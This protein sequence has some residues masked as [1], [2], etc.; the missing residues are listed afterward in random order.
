[1]TNIYKKIGWVVPAVTLSLVAGVMVGRYY[2]GDSAPRAETFAATPAAQSQNEQVLATLEALPTPQA[3]TEVTRTTSVDL[4]ETAIA[5][6]PVPQPA[7]KPVE[8]RIPTTADTAESAAF[9]AAAQANLQAENSCGDDLRALAGDA[10]VYFPTGGLSAGDAGLATA[11]LIGQVLRDCPGFT[12]QIEG[13]SDASG[14]PEFNRI[15][16]ERRANTVLSR[17]ASAGIDTSNFVALGLGDTQPS[18]VTG[19]EDDA[20]YDRRVE[21]TI[22]EDT[23]TASL[24][25]APQPWQ[26]TATPSSCIAVLQ[27]KAAQTRIFYTARAITVSPSEMETVKGLAAQTAACDGARLR[28]VGHH[29][30]TPAAREDASTG[31]LRVLAMM[32]S[33]VASGFESEKILIG[34]PSR[35]VDLAGQPGLPNS[36]V[37]FQIIAD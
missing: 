21:F 9:F 31:R 23:R 33:L 3:S 17:L 32:S 12:V 35:S 18:G 26:T 10:R 16:S 4:L 22:L 19:P 11:R 6:K 24:N 15:L 27:D 13:H 8:N 20:F 36:R 37:E 14:D 25:P 7:P 34:A 1:M 5:A 29:A 30:D 2:A 28:L